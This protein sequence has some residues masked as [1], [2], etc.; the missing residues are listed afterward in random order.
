MSG[1]FTQDCNGLCAWVAILTAA[2]RADITSQGESA[3]EVRLR[4]ITAQPTVSTLPPKQQ[5]LT[6]EESEKGGIAFNLASWPVGDKGHKQ[7]R[8]HIKSVRQSSWWIMWLEA[9]HRDTQRGRV[10]RM[11]EALHLACC[12][13]LTQPLKGTTPPYSR[14]RTE[15]EHVGPSPALSLDVIK[16]RKARGERERET[17]DSWAW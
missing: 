6:W 4:V 11:T 15:G 14:M 2:G 16:P 8:W 13:Q 9:M 7:E 17:K 1:G 5:V 10:Q 3:C 12:L